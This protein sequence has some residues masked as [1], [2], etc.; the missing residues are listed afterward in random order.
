MTAYPTANLISAVTTL[1][2]QEGALDLGA[3]KAA[4]EQLAEAPLDGVFV[5]GTTGEF[6]T[7]TDDE[8]LTV[9]AAANDAFGPD[10]TYWHVGA[11][12]ARQAA[13]LTQAA[14][15]R[16]ARRL[17]ALTPHYYAAT[18]TAVLRYYETVV[19]RARE[20]PVYGYL[21]EAR[22][23]TAVPPALLARL[24]ETGIAGVKIS[25]EGSPV[26]GQYLAALEGRTIPVYS[27]A[28]SEFAEVV[29]LGAA[30]VVSGV[31][32]ALP[33]PFL[34]VRDALRTGDTAAL[35]LARE[36]ARRAVAATRQGNLA[37]LKAVLELRGI[38][39][40]GLRAPLDP[41]SPEDRRTLKAD[42]ADLL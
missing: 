36:R 11:A 1:F 27:G 39:A 14:V 4:Y 21:F 24:A 18:E 23:T 6:T 13:S 30:G 32:S 28:D 38:P 37:H 41:I 15:D 26:I 9:C 22:T 40:S 19:S 5:A 34:D 16:G 3:T 33:E 42:I 29:D 8:R 35:A 7:L 31:S 2:D 10:R 12:S 20:V 17:A 25:G